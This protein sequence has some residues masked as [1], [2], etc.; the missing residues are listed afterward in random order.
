MHPIY[1]N[2]VHNNTIRGNTIQ[3]KT[4]QDNVMQ[5]IQLNGG[6]SIYLVSIRS[7]AYC[8][9]QLFLYIQPMKYILPLFMTYSI[10]ISYN[11]CLNASVTPQQSLKQTNSTYHYILLYANNRTLGLVPMTSHE[12]PYSMARY[13][14]P[15]FSSSTAQS[16]NSAQEN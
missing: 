11:I 3:Y 1:Y 10:R 15:G 8:F 9:Q 6:I 12:S 2:A 5:P 4:R 13:N 14:I 7:L 16:Y